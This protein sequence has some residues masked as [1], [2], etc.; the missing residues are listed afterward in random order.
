MAA[1]KEIEGGICAP[2]GFSAA[3]MHCGVRRNRTKKDL[4]LIASEKRAVSAG[5]FTQN[6]VK[7]APLV[8]SK[9]NLADGYASAI[10]INSGNAN[11]CNKNGLEIASQ[12]CELTAGCLG[13]DAK[14][15]LVASTGVI[16]A[17]LTL[18]AIGPGIREL[19][20]NMGDFSNDAA[21]AIMTTDLVKKELAVEFEIDG[22]PCRIGAIAKGSG[23]LHPDMATLLVFV[24]SDVDITPEMAQKLVSADVCD[25][26]N[27]L[28]IDG[29]TSTND[30]LFFMA[31]G[32]AG[33]AV[34]SGAGEAFDTLASVYSWVTTT[35][36]KMIAKDAEGATKL[37]TVNVSGAKDK[38]AAKTVA[39]A[40][41]S[42]IL[43]KCAVFGADANWGRVLC[44]I[45][46][47][48]A[49]V[50]INKIDVEFVS[51]GGQVKVC[52]N[53]YGLD[54]NEPTAR[55]TLLDDDIVINIALDEGE[56]TSTSW[57]CDL[58]YDYVKINGDYRT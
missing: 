24:T 58:T 34:V 28:T 25:S 6:L 12:M 54:F 41:A 31:N 30:T 43:V 42:S 48:G 13:F 17:E 16:G 38:Q 44:A 56:E 35:L 53:G 18:D 52:E 22:V 27:M 49:D 23:M 10:V 2:Q 29:D 39:K 9:E 55:R 20:R 26:F 45:G 5:V 15:I 1:F 19:S 50:D 32:L 11:T 40:V 46:Y 57:G 21:E 37:I 7:G 36:C 3:G 47:S 8:V 33:N 51:K 14:D 4:A